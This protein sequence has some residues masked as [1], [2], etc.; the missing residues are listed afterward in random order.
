M[1]KVRHGMLTLV[2]S[3]MILAMKNDRLRLATATM[4]VKLG[5]V[6]GLQ[7]RLALHYQENFVSVITTKFPLPCEVVI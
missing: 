1:K 2:W 3:I 5:E 4:L 7:R 6:A